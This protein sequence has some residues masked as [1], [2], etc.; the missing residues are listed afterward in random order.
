MSRNL[1]S[2]VEIVAP[3]EDPALRAQVRHLLDLQLADG[4][5]AWDMQPDGTYVQR[6]PAHGERTKSSQQQLI[7][8][9][10]KRHRQATRLK[11]R[12]IKGLRS[13]NQG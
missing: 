9:A 8:L 3:V 6:V 2:R 11:R 10:E 4:R 5:D 13:R 1:K 7:E 12:K